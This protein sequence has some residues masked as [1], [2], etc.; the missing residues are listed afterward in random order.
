MRYLSSPIEKKQT[1]RQ[2]DTHRGCDP[3]VQ[4]RRTKVLAD[5]II[6]A[7]ER[8]DPVV[9]LDIFFEEFFQES[10]LPKARIFIVDGLGNLVDVE[11]PP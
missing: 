9:N 4:R 11:V 3:L 5:G 6:Q 2:T 10:S 7:S 8:K 1:R